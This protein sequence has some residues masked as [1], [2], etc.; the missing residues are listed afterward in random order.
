[1]KRMDKKKQEFEEQQ[2]KK[3]EI[4]ALSTSALNGNAQ[5]AYRLGKIFWSQGKKDEAIE[6]WTLAGKNKHQKAP[7][8]LAQLFEKGEDVTLDL[9]KAERFYRIGAENG[10][11]ICE[12]VVAKLLEFDGQI[13]E[14]LRLKN[15][16]AEK[17]YYLAAAEMGYYY[18]KQGNHLK[19]K[20]CFEKAWKN[21]PE[22]AHF[23]VQLKTLMDY[24][25]QAEAKLLSP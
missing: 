18:A 23:T 9:E 12:Y 4:E 6:M 24:N 15:N 1:M 3:A 11:P 20:Q 5:D 22:D 17:G 21:A 19:A 10:H 7:Y 2:E 8:L 16:S 13:D 25:I 14:S